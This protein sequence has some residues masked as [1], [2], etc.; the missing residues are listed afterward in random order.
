[1]R[2]LLLALC[3]L[4]GCVREVT[5]APV[6][7]AE[8]SADSTPAVEMIDSPAAAGSGEPFLARSAR[9][10]AILMSWIET[11]GNV[12]SVRF[13]RLDP[14]SRRW[15]AP[16]TIATG[17]DY[18][19]NWADFPAV[20]QTADGSL[21]AHYLQKRGTGKY[22]YDVKVVRSQDEGKSWTRAVILHEDGVGAEHGFVSIVPES[23]DEVQFVWLDGRK[24][25]GGHAEDG[26]MSLRQRTMRSDGKMSPESELDGRTCECCQT[27]MAVAAGGPIVVYRDRSSENI[28]DI[29]VTRRVSGSWTDPVSLHA[30]E[31]KIDGCPVN[32]P[33]IDARG[34]NVAV[35]WFTGGGGKS[36]VKVKFS[37]DEG[38]TWTE[39]RVVDAGAPMGRVDISMLSD[40]EALVVW[41]EQNGEKA[42]VRGRVVERDGTMSDP[43]EV[44]PTTTSRSSGFPRIAV[45]K[46][47]VYAAWTQTGDAP[48][49][50]VAKIVTGG[51]K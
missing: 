31:W 30:D 32:G 40:D 41:I 13:S 7:D 22:S 46:D 11:V 15:S 4:A 1:M 8:K 29:S 6:E 2:R 19:V 42:E 47:G 33:Q 50:R 28:R 45:G 18:F 49:I 23:E 26:E 36:S 20:A 39:P 16:G 51:K 12:S 3:L 38:V 17:T 9:D 34:S 48:V 24:M 44:G 5:V 27:G 43:F 21:F 14:A 35:A 10:G 25:T 37:A